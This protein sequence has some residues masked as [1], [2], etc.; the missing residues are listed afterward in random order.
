MAF[1]LKSA[2]FPWQPT[3]ATFHLCIDVQRLFTQ[4][5]PWPTPWL[6][7]VLPAIARI[8][9]HAPERNIFSRFVPPE[10]PE[11][12]GGTWRA[13]Y[14]HWR[15][16]TLGLLDPALLNLASPLDLIA[17]AGTVIDKPVYSAFVG[18]GLAAFLA[19]Q[20]A[21][22]LVITGAETDVCV[23]ATVLDA[24]DLGY[25]IYI[26]TDAVCGSTDASHDAVLTLYRTRFYQQ[27]Q[28]LSADHLLAIWPR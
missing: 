7:A 16:A 6:E 8:A 18:T 12:M 11:D 5:G 10:Q 2:D 3:R 19:E 22:G 17:R 13:Y 4:D 9:E 27:I 20:R 24:V 1:E 28:T 21:D 25:P 23:L 26:V 14:R 15:Q